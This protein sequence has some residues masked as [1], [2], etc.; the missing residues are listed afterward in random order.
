M[1]Y[2]KIARE[3]N[4]RDHAAGRLPS[5]YVEDPAVLDKVARIMTDDGP[6]TQDL[7]ARILA[8]HAERSR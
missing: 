5:R 6:A 8:D 2:A 1:D 7:V 3:Q 4:D